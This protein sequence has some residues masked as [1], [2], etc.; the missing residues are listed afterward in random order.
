PAGAASRPAGRPGR[1][2]GP[3]PGEAPRHAAIGRCFADLAHRGP[4]RRRVARRRG[5]HLR[6]DV[7]L[8][9]GTDGGDRPPDGGGRA[10]AGRAAAVPRRGDAPCGGWMAAG[11]GR[12][13]DGRDLCRARD[14]MEDRVSG[15]R[16]ARV[17]PDGARDRPRLR[18]APR[19]QG[20]PAPPDPG[21]GDGPLRDHTRAMASPKPRTRV[22]L[23]DDDEA[24][25][26]LLT[27][28][29]DGFGFAV[30]A[31]ARPEEG[32]RLLAADPPDIVVLDVMLPGLDGFAVCRK[33]R[34]TSRVPIA[35]LTAR[36]GRIARIVH[37]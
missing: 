16:R 33:V 3:G 6:A 9:E 36:G 25:G 19:A 30:K 1:L 17:V 24:L 32:L 23:I 22:L 21:P 8:G 13:D 20:R 7:P 5:G 18:R 4:G 10:A 15:R 27:E 14:A 11:I 29:L 37:L 34:E 2:P 31:V 12:G 35:M 26:A 28:Y